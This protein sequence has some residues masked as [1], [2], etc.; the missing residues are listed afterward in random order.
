MRETVGGR[1]RWS[2]EEVAN[3]LLLAEETLEV[4]EEQA[5]SPLLEE[6]SAGGLICGCGWQLPLQ[7]C[8][9]NWRQ[10]AE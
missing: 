4:V 2:L 10:A 1:L 8:E 6:P 7:K 5:P 9:M 3:L